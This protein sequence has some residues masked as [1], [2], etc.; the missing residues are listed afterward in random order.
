[1]I[2][3]VVVC[4]SRGLALARGLFGLM[5]A[6]PNPVVAMV[7]GTEPG[8][9]GVCAARLPSGSSVCPSVRGADSGPA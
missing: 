5:I 2:V 9:P 7:R 3:M 1:M 6:E 4:G 8:V